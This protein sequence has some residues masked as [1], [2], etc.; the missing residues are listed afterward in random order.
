[1]SR[2]GDPRISAPSQ[3]CVCG[4]RKKKPLS[5]RVH[6]C[7]V[8]GIGPIQ[9]DLFS[10]FLWRHIDTDGIFDALKARKEL[11]RRQDI[12]VH[13]ASKDYKQQVPAARKRY[14]RIGVRAVL[15]LFAANTQNLIPD[16]GNV[17][18][19]PVKPEMSSTSPR[20]AVEVLAAEAVP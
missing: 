18:V 8:C 12:A 10:A 19:S 17:P 2:K 16:M 5:L 15:E 14:G 9:R 20:S 4:A 13:E 1:M 6:E 3:I 7:E 11:S